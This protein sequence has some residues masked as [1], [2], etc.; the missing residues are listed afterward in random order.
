MSIKTIVITRPSG[1]AQQL[2]VL[3]YKCLQ[4]SPASQAKPPEIISLPLLTIL[5][6]K[7]SALAQDIATSLH[8]ADLAIFVSPNA[9][10][11]TMR[12]LECSWQ[13]LTN[14]PVPIGVMGG[15]SL[16]ALSSYGIGSESAPTRLLY[17]QDSTEW[18]SEGLWKALQKLQWDWPTKRVVILKG[19]GGRDWLANTLKVAGAHLDLISVYSRIPLDLESPIWGDIRK[20]DFAQSLWLLTSSEAA[21]HLGRA[22]LSLNLSVALC[23]HPNIA[24]AARQIGFREIIVCEPGDDA[25]VKASQD[26][27]ERQ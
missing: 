23:S 14:S 17:P 27:L 6:A 1:Q 10:E 16:T 15:G 2:S 26:W 11:C 5:P 18:D 4:K 13:E 21:R 20:I 8:M 12:L 22:Q 25:L 7:G 9:I 3:L 19:E 24:D